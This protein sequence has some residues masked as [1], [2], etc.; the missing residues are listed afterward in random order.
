MQIEYRLLKNAKLE[1]LVDEIQAAM[2]DGWQLFNRYQYDTAQQ[3]YTQE[4]I[5]TDDAPAFPALVEY[6]AD[7]A[8]A[9]ESHTALINNTSAG[10][11]TLA[12]PTAADDGKII[13]LL[14]GTDFAHTIT[15]AAANLLVDAFSGNE[16]NRLTLTGPLG[17]STTLHVADGKY[18]LSAHGGG[19]ISDV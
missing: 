1:A 2:A 5:K 7:G 18:W 16:G 10:A 19:V 3:R 4:M 12:V 13:P 8:I 11:Y 15:T 14:K 17:H 6:P 9:V